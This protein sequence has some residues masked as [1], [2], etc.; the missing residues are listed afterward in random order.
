MERVLT[1]AGLYPRGCYLEESLLASTEYPDRYLVESKFSPWTI[2]FPKT[3]SLVYLSGDRDSM[4]EFKNTFKVCWLLNKWSKIY[5]LL[6]YQ[7]T[8]FWMLV[9]CQALSTKM[10]SFNVPATLWGKYNH[11]PHFANA[12]FEKANL[13]DLLKK[14]SD[15]T[16]FELKWS[17][18]RACVLITMLKDDGARLIYL[19]PSPFSASHF[20]SI[21]RLG[22]FENLKCL[23]HVNQIIWTHEMGGAVGYVNNFSI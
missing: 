1:C 6:W 2:S 4:K 16:V 23:L 13:S 3:V 8:F 18:S 7:L 9:M 15:R 11:Y 21:D 22:S 20:V 12:K 10:I 19:A 14:L 5:H 17:D